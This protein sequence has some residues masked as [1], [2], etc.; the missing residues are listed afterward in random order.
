MQ[1]EAHA[2]WRYECPMKQRAKW[3]IQ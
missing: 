2:C 1:Q 3:P